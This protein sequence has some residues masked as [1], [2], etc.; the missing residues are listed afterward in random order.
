MKWAW[1]FDNGGSNAKPVSFVE[2]C[3]EYENG[4]AIL[5]DKNTYH[6][7]LCECLGS[8]NQDDCDHGAIIND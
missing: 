2:A 6:G 4:G 1:E 3:S 5:R 7:M 8:K